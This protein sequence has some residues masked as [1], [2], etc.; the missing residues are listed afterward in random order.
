MFQ[1]ILKY[2][3]LDRETK[4]VRQQAQENLI[5]ASA[6]LDELK[7]RLEETTSITVNSRTA[8]MKALRESDFGKAR[9]AASSRG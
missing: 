3:G 8:T 9:R 5:K 1:A 2:L 4:R 7:V 6:A